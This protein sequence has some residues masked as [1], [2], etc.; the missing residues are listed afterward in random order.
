MKPSTVKQFI[1][2]Q[3]KRVGKVTLN[4]Y[5]RVLRNSFKLAVEDKVISI[6]PAADM[7]GQRPDTCVRARLSEAIR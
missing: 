2:G 4:A 6:S 5:S 7:K 3:S 1:A